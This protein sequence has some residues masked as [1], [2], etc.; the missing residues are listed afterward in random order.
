MEEKRKKRKLRGERNEERV[1]IIEGTNR[2]S[3]SPVDTI[4]KLVKGN[5]LYKMPLNHLTFMLFPP[6]I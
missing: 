2:L 3:G 5:S 4:R 1:A 6:H